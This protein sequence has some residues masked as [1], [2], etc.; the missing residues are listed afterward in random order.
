MVPK[1][2]PDARD[3]VPETPVFRDHFTALYSL[4]PTFLKR[5]EI[6]TPLKI[7]TTG[8]GIRIE[9][10]REFDPDV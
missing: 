2:L 8:E 7:N 9:P 6:A 3:P 4:R 1:H 10:F 5:R